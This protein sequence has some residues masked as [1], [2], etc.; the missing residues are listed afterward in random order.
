MD[1]KIPMEMKNSSNPYALKVHLSQ[2]LFRKKEEDR[3]G[4]GTTNIEEQLC[5]AFVDNGSALAT[6]CKTAAAVPLTIWQ[7]AKLPPDRKK[8]KTEIKTEK[9]LRHAE[10]LAYFTHKSS[11]IFLTIFFPSSQLSLVR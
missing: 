4:Y 5:A 9:K 7:T 1:E 8:N 11:D 10:L 3:K 6:I 2:Y